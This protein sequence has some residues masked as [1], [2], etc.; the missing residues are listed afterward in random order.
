M[1]KGDILHYLCRVPDAS[2]ADVGASL[3]LSLPAAG[4]ALLRLTR[5]GLVCRTFDPHTQCYYYALTD[6]GRARLQF[7]QQEAV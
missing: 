1:A 4:M 2:A 3:G 7:L 6:K 5:A